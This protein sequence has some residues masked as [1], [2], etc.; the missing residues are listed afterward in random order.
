MPIPFNDKTEAELQEVL[1]RL[2][3]KH[4]AQNGAGSFDQTIRKGLL[5]MKKK[6]HELTPEEQALLDAPPPAKQQ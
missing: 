3:S 6:S 1:K 2:R 5:M 4:E